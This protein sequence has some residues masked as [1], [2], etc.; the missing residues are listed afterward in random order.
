MIYIVLVRDRD[1]RTTLVLE[2]YKTH[3][4]WVEAFDTNT[5]KFMDSPSAEVTGFVGGSKEQFLADHP[6]LE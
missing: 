6:E 2:E 5:R 1:A 4:E 3:E